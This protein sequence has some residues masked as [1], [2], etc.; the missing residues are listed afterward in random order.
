[1]FNVYIYLAIRGSAKVACDTAHI[2]LP[3]NANIPSPSPRARRGRFWRGRP[4]DHRWIAMI[5]CVTILSFYQILYLLDAWME[6]V[7]V[8]QLICTIILGCLPS[9]IWECLPSRMPRLSVQY[10][11]NK[12]PK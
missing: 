10:S 5:W 11:V 9:R 12:G 7:S 1:M 6:C 4:I 8:W 3:Y 2:C